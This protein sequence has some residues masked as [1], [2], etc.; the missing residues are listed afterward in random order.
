MP[1]LSG[2]RLGTYEVIAPLGRGGMGEVWL[3]RDLELDRRVALKVLPPDFTQDTSRV[4][5]FQQEARAASGLNHPNVCTIH[6]LGEAPDGQRFIAMEYVEGETLRQRL[7]S[8]RLTLAQVLDTAVQVASGLTAAH[9]AGIVHRDLKPENVMIRPDGLVKVLDF[10]L[11][12]LAPLGAAFTGEEATRGVVQTDAGTVVG[13]TAYMSPEQAR[14]QDVDARTDIWS[15]GVMLYEMVAGQR[16]FAGPSSSDV[17]AA[18]LDREPVP[19]GRLEPGT[20]PELHRIVG[21]T[22][23]KD[24]EQRYQG[25]KD[26]LLDLKALGDDVAVRARSGGLEHELTPPVIAPTPV[27]SSGA[28]TTA[29]SSSAEYVVS[30]LA[31]HKVSALLA[32]FVL[33]SLAGA[34]WWVSRGRSSPQDVAQGPTSVQRTLTRMTFDEGLQAEPT[35][36]PDGRL[37]AYSSNRQGNFD[38]WV[39]SGTEGNP[40]RVTSSAAHDW[41]PD[42]SPDG[43]RIVYRSERDGGALVIVPA[44]GGNERKV[45]GFGYGPSWSPDGSEILFYGSILQTGFEASNLYLVALDGKPPRELLPTLIR[46][47]TFPYLRAAW[48]PDGR[49][50]SIWGRHREAGWSL[51]TVP[52][53]GGTPVMSAFSEEVAPQMKEAAVTFSDF[54][55]APSADALYFVGD[56][57]SVTNLWKVSVEPQTLRWIAGPE[58]LTTSAGLD[59]DIALSADGKKLAFTA[60]TEQSRIWSIPFDPAIGRTT[61]P[62][63]PITAAS[64]NGD[65][66]ALT[67]DGKRMAFV[68]RRSGRQ[69]LWAKS[70]G[71]GRETLLV[72]PDGLARAIPRWSHDGTRLAYRRSRFGSSETDLSIV[73]LPASGGDEQVLT[74]VGPARETALDW[75]AD[76]A[77]ILANS[78][79]R[80]PGRTLICLLPIAAAPRAETQMRVVAADPEQSLFQARFSPG[81]RW[82]SFNA[83]KP[84]DA[85]VSTIYVVPSAGGA[86]TR[87]TDGKDWND[88][89][90]WSPDGKTIYYVSNRTGFF[91][92]WGIRFDPKNGTPVG[93]PFRVTTFDSPGQMV[94][95]SPPSWSSRSPPTAWCSPFL[96]CRAASG[97]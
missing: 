33:A 51:W 21:K 77:W 87:I 36:S 84:S 26:L 56:S 55:W 28:A 4:S 50:I 29:R 73:L 41:Q 40:L 8:R 53:A 48:H 69:E 92:V 67:A 6:S 91:N 34:A 10:G 79:R 75:S 83:I 68:A 32:A 5:R 39:Q 71:D 16:P 38:I 2:S 96:R 60:R 90:R 88:K 19:L 74:S 31:R 95:P 70:L 62:G 17:L 42:W 13:T 52:I 18:I 3:A 61:G 86:W 72:P 35:W 63:L 93:E 64:V 30:Q 89:A 78:T 1:F 24:K 14:G 57:R 44:L 12:K 49:R 25:M 80:T 47:F 54:I 9:G 65:M 82:I 20:P 81:E 22:L 46:Q 11:A 94:L 97:L 85:G 23:R 37:I 27:G 7:G 76:G 66:P 43:S 59:A 45:S 15:L 58:R